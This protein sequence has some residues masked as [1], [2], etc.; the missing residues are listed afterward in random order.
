ME[1]SVRV[2]IAFE[3]TSTSVA[4][5]QM[6]NALTQLSETVSDPE[7]KKLFETEMD[8]FF[9][10]FRRY[11]NDKA[12]GNAVDWDRI[13]PPAQGQ[14]GSDFKKVSDFQKHIPSIPKIIELDHLTITGAVNLG[15][16]VTLKGTVIIVA[17][18]GS[19]IDVPPGSILENV[20]V[21]GSLRL[22]EH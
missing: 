13:A 9:A 1:A 17:T 16:G 19:T 20:V 15:R 4:A 5:A 2:D 11:L 12:K 14:L 6:R 3:N 21:Q 22:L 8:N 18:E 7:Q 10:L